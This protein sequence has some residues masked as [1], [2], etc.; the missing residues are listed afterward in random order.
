MLIEEARQKLSYCVQLH[1]VGR[2]LRFSYT[3]TRADGIVGTEVS[4]ETETIQPGC[5]TMLTF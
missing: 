2:V 5:T 1:D 3:P 4:I